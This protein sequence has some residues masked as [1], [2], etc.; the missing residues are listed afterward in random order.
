VAGSRILRG[1]DLG[2][3]DDEALSEKSRDG[4]FHWLQIG[5][6]QRV[7][8]EFAG[9]HVFAINDD[10]FRRVDTQSDPGCL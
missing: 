10:V 8:A 9:V 3:I 7:F 2:A 5:N 4:L 6:S 1:V